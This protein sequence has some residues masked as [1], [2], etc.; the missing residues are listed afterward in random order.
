[1]QIIATMR[2][3]LTPVRKDIIK[4]LQTINTGE[5]VEEREPSYTA[6][7]SVDWCNYYGEKSGNLRNY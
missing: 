1:M 4:N 7:G 5:A 3:H 2:F 6:G